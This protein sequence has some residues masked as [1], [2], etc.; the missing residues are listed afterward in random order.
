MEAKFKR[1]IADGKEYDI[2]FDTALGTTKIIRMWAELSDTI[3]L[4]KKVIQ[5]SVPQTKAISKVLKGANTYETCQNI[6]NFVYR[7]INYNKDEK[8]KEQVR[9]ALRTWQDRHQ[10]V[11]CDCYTVFICS[12]L[13]NLKIP[14]AFRIAKYD[15]DV[16]FQH[17]YPIVPYE[18]R[19]LVIDCVLDE[20]NKEHPYIE[21]KDFWI[22][23]LKK[24]LG[25]ITEDR[26]GYDYV[27][28]DEFLNGE[29]G[30]L[31]VLA[32]GAGI[33]K[34]GALASILS[35]G[36]GILQNVGGAVGNVVQ[37]VGKILGIGKN[38]EAADEAERVL[39]EAKGKLQTLKTQVP[40]EIEQ[41]RA[42]VAQARQN[43]ENE[44]NQL[45]QILNSI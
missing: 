19:Y 32:V 16:G 1:N 24:D 38:K 37:N 7:H 45:T 17:V 39:A 2:F 21:K 18:G 26:K 3:K 31:P 23:E 35:K 4:M 25:F 40:Q 8:G 22:M 12:I 34:S 28:D 14:N 9:T 20:F 33:A 27:P 29:I 5:E 30:V 6:W 36:S 11:D 10:G 42:M 41:M 15:K 13:C 43:Y 44:L